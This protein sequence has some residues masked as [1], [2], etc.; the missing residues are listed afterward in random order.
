MVFWFITSGIGFWIYLGTSLILPSEQNSLTNYLVKSI[1]GENLNLEEKLDQRSIWIKKADKVLNF[2][3]SIIF[4]SLCAILLFGSFLISLIYSYI[5]TGLILQKIGFWQES[6]WIT[7]DIIDFENAPT[8]FI[9]PFFTALLMTTLAGCYVL[10]K[11]IKEIRLPKINPKNTYKKISLLGALLVIFTVIQNIFSVQTPNLAKK[12]FP[13]GE[14]HEI[15]IMQNYAKRFFYPTKYKVIIQKSDSNTVSLIGEKARISGLIFDFQ[16][17]KEKAVVTNIYPFRT[18]FGQKPEV[19]VI[20]NTNQIGIKV[21]PHT[22]W[23]IDGNLTIHQ[24][25]V[26]SFKEGEIQFLENQENVIFVK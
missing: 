1:L 17:E 19:T 23:T 7:T 2:V 14:A 11:L 6:L 18:C 3:S 12:N 24:T 15:A 5:C 25:I 21:V 16:G 8:W 9:I 20:I 22:F 10:V 13:I 26:S 4:R